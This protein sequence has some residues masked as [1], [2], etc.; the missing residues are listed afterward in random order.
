MSMINVYLNKNR[1]SFLLVAT[2]AFLI[3]PAF[4]ASS[5]FAHLLMIICMSFLFIQG[6]YVVCNTKK[7]MWIGLIPGIFIIGLAWFNF[8]GRDNIIIHII[9]LVTYII[10]FSFI[11]ISLI[12]FLIISKKVTIDVIIVAIAIYFLFGIIG[13]GINHL[14]YLTVENTFNIPESFD[15][16]DLMTFTY[17]SFVTM[18]T[19]GFGDM[20]PTTE[21]TQVTAFMLAIIGQFYIAII[22]AILIGKFVSKPRKS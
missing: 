11:A 6:L 20:T 15:S 3:V 13:G 8:L 7:Q 14:I 12:R 16:I 18:T 5:W 21:E 22:M 4:M 1:Y 17:F 2:I 10:F 9:Q 19:L